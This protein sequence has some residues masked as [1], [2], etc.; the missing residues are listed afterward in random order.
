MAEYA[1]GDIHACLDPLQQLL[2]TLNF[3]PACDHLWLTGDLVGRGPEPAA[4]LRFIRSL[5]A[6]A[7]SVLGNHD[8]HCLAVA[9]G[10]ARPRRKDRLE[11]L[12]QAADCDELLQWLRQRPL[13]LDLPE[14]PY[15]LVHAGIP[16]QWDIDSALAYAGEAQAILRSEE[17]PQ[18]FAHLYGNK[19]KYWNSQLQGWGR[20]RFIINA[21]TRM[22]FCTA[23]GGLEFAHN[24]P[25]EQAPEDLT[26]WYAAP[27]NQLDPNRATLITGHWSRLGCRQGTGYLTLDTGCLWGGALTAVRLDTPEPVFTQ[28]ACPTAMAPD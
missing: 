8:L 5:G 28:L 14:L 9:A 7:Q 24:G 18:F 23:D 17:A 25:P 3:D 13:M 26:P 19:P 12:L 15:A 1:V 20:L 6:S 21:L 11:P 2:E 4:T 10:H 22:R 27:G 16:P